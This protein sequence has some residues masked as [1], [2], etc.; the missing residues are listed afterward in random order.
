MFIKE[1]ESE[2]ESRLPFYRVAADR[3]LAC[4]DGV[5][6]VNAGSADR[7]VQ[8]RE[9]ENCSCPWPGNADIPQCLS[10]RQKWL[11]DAAK[12]FRPVSGRQM[13]SSSVIQCH[14]VANA[15]PSPMVL[16]RIS[17]DVVKLP[18][19]GHCQA[20]KVG[21]SASSHGERRPWFIPVP[22]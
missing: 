7:T 9:H 21:V 8:S 22:I 13:T 19:F 16:G 2:T 6:V 20:A 15:V 3:S 12:C 5:E 17:R 11:S 18:I 14:P 10:R 4:R 1:C